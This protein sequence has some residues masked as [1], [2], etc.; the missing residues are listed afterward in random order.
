MIRP[1]IASLTIHGVAGYAL[2]VG[3]PA[4]PSIDLSPDQVDIDTDWVAPEDDLAILTIDEIAEDLEL[5]EEAVEA[6]ESPIEDLELQPDVLPETVEL[7]ATEEPDEQLP[8]L[9]PVQP[10]QLDPLTELEELAAQ[11]ESVIENAAQPEFVPPDDSQVEEPALDP[12]IAEPVEM[13]DVAFDPTQDAT[14]GNGIDPTELPEQVEE[15]LE[16]SEVV[17]EPVEAPELQPIEEPGLTQAEID[18][19]TIAN[20]G[21]TA[22]LQEALENI[23]PDDQS[24]A[25]LEDEILEMIE[26]FTALDEATD[27]ANAEEL[28]RVEQAEEFIDEAAEAFLASVGFPKPRPRTRPAYFTPPEPEPEADPEPEITEEPTPT[29]ANAAETD[30]S[31]AETTVALAGADGTGSTAET[32]EDPALVAARQAARNTAN[33]AAIGRI[34]NLV[35]DRLDWPVFVTT[36]AGWEVNFE[37]TLNADGTF[38][39]VRKIGSRVPPGATPSEINAVEQAAQSAIFNSQPWPIPQDYILDWLEPVPFQVKP[40]QSFF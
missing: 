16:V 25:P 39:Q 35:N 40:S 8:D 37:V 27:Q 4:F 33:Q 34:R 38:V 3:L 21:D 11:L 15:P 12:A 23:A 26:R 7:A 1:L 36:F 17:E 13:P 14:L 30:Q 24:P 28:E 10:P 31:T 2:L 22:A 18:E 32:G 19:L 9:T 20:G 29:A 6:V 5:A